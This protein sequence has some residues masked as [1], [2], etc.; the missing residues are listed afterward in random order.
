MSE[1]QMVT[2]LDRLKKRVIKLILFIKKLSRL[3]LKISGPD[4][5]L[6][7]QDGCHHSKTGQIGPDFKWSSSLDHFKKEGH[8]KYFVHDKTVKACSQ[9]VRSGF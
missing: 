8:K 7:K 9:N 1:F 2:S 6:Q 4:F 5:E 3:V